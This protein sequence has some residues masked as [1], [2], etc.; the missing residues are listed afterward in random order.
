MRRDDEG[1]PNGF[2]GVVRDITDRKQAEKELEEAHRRLAE[3][4]EF[5]PDATFVIDN[6]GIIIAWNRAIEEITGISKNKMIGKGDYEYALPLYGKRRPLLIDLVR[7]PDQEG[8]RQYSYINHEGDTLYGE[9]YA[10][11]LYGGKGAYLWGAASVLYG[12]SGNPVGAIE[13]I[14]D[15]FDRKIYEDKLRYLSLH[16]Q[17]TGLYN[18][19]YFDNELNRL[20]ES[21]DYPITII[22]CD[23]DGLKLINDT[24]GHDSGDRL[25]IACGNL[26]KQCLRASDILARVGGDEFVAI[27]PNTGIKSGEEIGKRIMDQVN[28]Y[29]E[30]NFHLPLSISLG[31]ATLESSEQTLWD[32][33]KEAD[34]L[35]YRDKLHKGAGAKSQIIKSLM[36]ALGERDFITEGHANRLEELCRKVGEK[37]N[38]SNKQLSDL[39]LLAQ[40]HDLGKVGIP[41]QILFKEGPLNKE[42][43]K[44]MRTHTEKGHRIAA[45]STDL[46]GIADLILHHH[47]RWDGSGYPEGLKGKAIP[48]ECG[49]L[50][51]VDAYDAML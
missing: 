1:N 7:V 34:D 37:I 25:L 33:Y 19:A 3:I 16:D 15:I 13:T 51:I 12:T 39:T 6:E 38:L 36:A 49:I 32:T 21:R 2:C 20:N 9:T 14:R 46:H 45:A 23:L 28:E 5:L 40:V 41:D 4:I 22:V 29:N 48:V 18:R 43:W 11:N 10:G 24:L 8:Y 50:A 17:L 42:E 47:E 26:L 31:T 35:M 27:L 44:I 30:D